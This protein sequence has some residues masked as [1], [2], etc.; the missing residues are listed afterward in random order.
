VTLGLFGY[1]PIIKHLTGV[2]KGAYGSLKS[3]M[4]KECVGFLTSI[5]HSTE[6]WQYQV[7]TKNE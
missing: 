4:K 5:Y 1:S 2:P 7:P 3:G 6:C